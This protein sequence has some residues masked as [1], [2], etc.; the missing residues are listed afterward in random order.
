MSARRLPLVLSVALLTLVSVAGTATADDL[1]PP[2]YRGANRSTS[3]EWDFDTDQPNPKIQPD[4]DLP[5]V[6]GDAAPLL[7]GAFPAS[8]PHPSCGRSGGVSWTTVAGDTG[9]LGGPAGTGAI[10][11]NVP[12]WIDTEPEKQLRVQ[13]TYSGT[14]PTTAIFGFLGVPG[15]SSTVTEVFVRRVA[16]TSPDLPPG[17]SYYFEDWRV[18]PNPD[19]EQVVVFLPA[20]TFLHQLVID[21][22]SG[23][24]SDDFPIFNDG[25]ETGDTSRW[26]L[27]VQ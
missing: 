19:W 11:C 7:N 3:A 1:N 8:A 25:F 27:T 24:M 20:G 17:A 13:V 2:A 15:T 22:I 6:V 21:S 9:Y 4:G 12:N 5:V 14:R 16:D 10:A 23:A 18:F 26:S